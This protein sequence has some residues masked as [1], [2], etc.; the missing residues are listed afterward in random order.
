ML[1]PPLFSTEETKK[2]GQGV[3]GRQS[4]EKQSLMGLA[5]VFVASSKARG[6]RGC[7]RLYF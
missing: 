3:G 1:R 4:L 2:A 7:G 6:R 5:R